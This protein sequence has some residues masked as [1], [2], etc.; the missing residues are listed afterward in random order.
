MET[1]NNINEFLVRV[2]LEGHTF[3]QVASDL[4]VDR[5]NLTQWEKDHKERYRQLAKARQVYRRKD[6]TTISPRQFLKW[7]EESE[8]RCRYCKIT[9]EE[10]K[11][12]KEHGEIK[13]KRWTTRGRTLEIER[14]EPNEKY[15]NINN[16]TY[17]CYWCNNA[18]T[19]EFSEAEFV[20]IGQLIGNNWNK[21]LSR[22][23]EKQGDN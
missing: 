11:L 21:R 13:T 5:K 3:D 14:R 6:F 15:D 8:R 12:L 9:E 22:I 2:A 4:G 23:R 17:C 18:K 20:Y 1:E 7:F 10:I 16:L 19:D